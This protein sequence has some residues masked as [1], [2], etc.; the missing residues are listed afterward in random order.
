MILLDT[1]TFIWWTS[2]R[3]QLSDRIAALLAR[4][5]A[6]LMISVVTAWEIAILHKKGRLALPL[7]P[8]TFLEKALVHHGIH[9]LPLTRAIALKAVD[10]PNIHNDPFDRILIAEAGERQCTLATK[11]ALI[12][13]YPDIQVAW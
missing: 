5:S 13:R 6:G 12:A 2:D 9:E 8:T 1:H 10:L 11:D 7:A 4:E 3:S